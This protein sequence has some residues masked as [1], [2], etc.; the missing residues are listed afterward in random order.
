VLF[1]FC[2]LKFRICYII[3]VSCFLWEKLQHWVHSVVTTSPGTD[4]LALSINWAH[5]GQCTHYAPHPVSTIGIRGLFPEHSHLN[6]L[7]YR[8][9]CYSC[10]FPTSCLPASHLLMAPCLSYLFILW[11]PY[12]IISKLIDSLIFITQPMSLLLLVEFLSP[13]K[14]R[15]IEV[16]TPKI[17]KCDFIWK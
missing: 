2:Y 14:R 6:S 8:H 15:Y 17:C 12:L 13:L 11:S 4:H 5:R 10:P 9:Q 7:L 1:S 16:P 3:C